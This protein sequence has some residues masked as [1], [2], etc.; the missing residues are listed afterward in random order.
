MRRFRFKYYNG[1]YNI[2]ID[3]VGELTEIETNIIEDERGK[4]RL[5]AYVDKQGNTYYSFG[6]FTPNNLP[7]H[8][9][10]WSSR[11]EVINEVFGT[12]LIECGVDSRA[13]SI[14]RAN[15][16]LGD[17][18]QWKDNEIQLKRSRLCEFND[19]YPSALN[20]D[21]ANQFN[22]GQWEQEH[23]DNE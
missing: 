9:G 2:V 7:G 18:L 23:E 1:Y 6:V 15:V 14:L 13:M 20:G 3:N 5:T 11:T 21:M 16:E 19:D 12:D 17:L 10:E 22:E 4:W 8:G